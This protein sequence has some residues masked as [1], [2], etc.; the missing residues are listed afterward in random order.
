MYKELLYLHLKWSKGTPFKFKLGNPK[1]E[2]GLKTIQALTNAPVYSP[3]Q[4]IT[5]IQHALSDKYE[6]WQR[7]LMLGGWTPYNVGIERE[8]KKSKKTKKYEGVPVIK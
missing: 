8:K 5:N 7:M 2:A 4:N 3:Y 6:T 1:L